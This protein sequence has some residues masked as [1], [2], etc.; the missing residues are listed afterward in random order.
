MPVQDAV[1][2]A[3]VNPKLKR[4][5]ER[6]LRRL[7]LTKTEAIR[8]FLRQIQSRGTLPFSAT[9][10]KRPVESN[11][12]LLLPVEKRRAALDALYES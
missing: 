3:R 6:I 10:A 7:G 5:S 12:D 8:M 11:D 2:S 9:Q 1:I 4:D